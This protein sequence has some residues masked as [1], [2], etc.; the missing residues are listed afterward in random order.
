MAKHSLATFDEKGTSKEKHKG[1]VYFVEVVYHPTRA[2]RNVANQLN[3]E[4]YERIVANLF[5]KS[6]QVVPTRHAKKTRGLQWV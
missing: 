5:T 4:V 1:K 3:K 2:A 6:S